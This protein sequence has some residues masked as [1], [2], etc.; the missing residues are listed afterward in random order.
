MKRPI[1]ALLVLVAAV[2]AI[3]GGLYARHRASSRGAGPAGADRR[4]RFAFDWPRGTT[5]RYDFALRAESEVKMPMPADRAGAQRALG[6]RADLAGV[7]LLSSFGKQGSAY[8]LSARIERLTAHDLEML[9]SP[10]FSGEHAANDALV[11]RDAVLEVDGYGDV[12]AVYFDADAPPV[13]KHVMEGLLEQAQVVVAAN[14]DA[15]WSVT[16]VTPLGRGTAR[17]EVESTSAPTV[18]RT[19]APYDAIFALPQRRL[20]PGDQSEDERATIALDPRGFVASLVDDESLHVKRADGQG[21]AAPGE[22]LAARSRFTMTLRDVGTFTPVDRDVASLD[23]RQPGQVVG[24]ADARRQILEQRAAGLTP[25]AMRTQILSFGLTGTF[26]AKD[27]LLRASAL[28]TLH[29]ELCMDL[30]GLFEHD[31]MTDRGRAQIAQLLAGTGTP[32]AQSALRAALESPAARANP[33]LYRSA[34]QSFLVVARPTRE[35]LEFLTSAF[36]GARGLDDV[37]A[38]ALALGAAAGSAYR[39]GDPDA[40]KPIDAALVRALRGA[41]SADEKAALLGAIGNVGMPDDLATIRDYARD[42]EADVRAAAAFALRKIDTPDARQAL[43][44]FAADSSPDVEKNAFDALAYES[45]G[46]DDL[47]ELAQ[48]VTSGATS[49][50]SDSALLTLLSS[51]VAAGAPVRAMLEHL[52]ARNGADNM[53]MA[54]IRHLIASA[55]GEP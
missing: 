34:V 36:R 35:S 13:F 6:G 46:A 45:L 5:Y 7:L 28:L 29:P 18:T 19:R 55:G 17:Y 49:Q 4:L 23:A 44:G 43:L 42:D 24:P 30:A 52:L 51:H 26:P 8:R 20:A 50:R 11:G 53:M 38:T 25:D 39:S 12:R 31:A 37:H 47:A 21:A 14:G 41:K 40:A 1:A 9:G 3:G 15:T 27:W 54:E 2:L 48:V 16:E 10:V 32:E 22:D 33:V